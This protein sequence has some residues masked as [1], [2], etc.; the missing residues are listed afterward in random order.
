MILKVSSN[1]NDPVILW[2]K[3]DEWSKSNIYDMNIWQM[4]LTEEL[5]DSKAITNWL[6]QQ[7]RLKPIKSRTD[8][9]LT[10][11]CLLDNH[12]NQVLPTSLNVKNNKGSPQMT[13]RMDKQ[14]TGKEMNVA[15]L[16]SDKLR[17]EMW[18]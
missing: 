6:K 11:D 18:H 17:W 15:L 1:L 3:V 10:S 13:Q 9:K 14:L 2:Y 8:T 12:V 7:I 4:K 16:K 5:K